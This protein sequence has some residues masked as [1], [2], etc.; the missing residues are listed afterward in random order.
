MSMVVRLCVCVVYAYR[1]CLNDRDVSAKK[2]HR[3][4][5]RATGDLRAY[6][7][8][9]S[10]LGKPAHAIISAAHLAPRRIWSVDN[11]NP[12]NTNIIEFEID[13][14][15]GNRIGRRI[16]RALKLGATTANRG[17]GRVL[18]QEPFDPNA[19]DGDNDGL[20]QD[21]TAF[22]RPAVLTS[23]QIPKVPVP[24][25]ALSSATPSE[26][27]EKLPPIDGPVRKPDPHNPEW[28][29]TATVDEL[30]DLYIPSTTEGYYQLL[31]RIEVPREA[32][33]TEADYQVALSLHRDVLEARQLLPRRKV[34]AMRSM[35]EAKFGPGSFDKDSNTDRKKFTSRVQTLF[36]NQQKFGQAM[37]YVPVPRGAGLSPTPAVMMQIQLAFLNFLKQNNI[38]GT[39]SQIIKDIEDTID[40]GE[41][42]QHPMFIEIRKNGEINPDPLSVMEFMLASLVAPTGNLQWQTTQM[43]QSKVRISPDVEQLIVQLLE[44]Y[45][46]WVSLNT[47][48]PNQILDRQQI[49]NRLQLAKDSGSLYGF[50]GTVFPTRIDMIADSLVPNSVPS[51]SKQDRQLLRA[52]MK[53]TLKENP[54]FLFAVRKFGLPPVMIPH[55]VFSWAGTDFDFDDEVILASPNNTSNRIRAARKELYDKLNSLWREFGSRSAE[56]QRLRNERFKALRRGTITPQELIALQAQYLDYD[57]GASGHFPVNPQLGG[58]FETSLGMVVLQH[59][60]T[61][62]SILKQSE[63]DKGILEIENSK[64]LVDTVGEPAVLVHEYAHYLDNLLQRNFAAAFW[65]SWKRSGRT[66]VKAFRDELASRKTNLGFGE[67][68]DGVNTQRKLINIMRK[69]RNEPEIGYVTPEEIPKGVLLYDYGNMSDQELQKVIQDL[70]SQLEQIHGSSILLNRRLNGIENPRDISRDSINSS[71]LYVVTPYGQTNTAERFAEVFAAAVTRTGQKHPILINNAAVKLIARILGLNVETQD[72]TR[73]QRRKRD[74]NRSPGQPRRYTDQM[75]DISERILTDLK[76]VAPEAERKADG[77]RPGLPSSTSSESFRFDPD[78]RSRLS[79]RTNL[80]IDTDE[81]LYAA[82]TPTLL[83][84]YASRARMLKIGDHHFYDKRVPF[85]S[86]LDQRMRQSLGETAGRRYINRNRPHHGDMVRAIS[87]IQFG[88]FVDDMPIYD[89]TT[90]GNKDMLRGLVTGKIA[91]LPLSKRF[92]IEEALRDA[93][94]IHLAVQAVE[95]N[96]RELFRIISVDRETFL[97]GLNTGD[98]IP[99]PITA[100]SPDKPNKNNAVVIRLEKGAKAINLGNGHFLTQGNF[101]VTKIEDNGTNVIATLSHKEVFDPRHDAMRPVD[102][103]SDVPGKMRKMGAALARY[104]PEEQEKMN[105]ELQKRKDRTEVLKNRGLASSTNPLTQSE[106]TDFLDFERSNINREEYKR[107][108][109]PLLQRAREI[110]SAH[111]EQSVKKRLALSIQVIKEKYGTRTPW[112]DDADAIRKW[113]TIDNDTARRAVMVLRDLL[114]Q[115]G[116]IPFKGNP[117]SVLDHQDRIRHL[118][119]NL[120][121]DGSFSESDLEQLL[122]K[123]LYAFDRNSDSDARGEYS[124]E[125]Q[126]NDFVP[127]PQILN[128]QT[129]EHKELRQVLEIALGALKAVK[130]AYLLDGSTFMVGDDEIFIKPETTNNRSKGAFVRLI[131]DEGGERLWNY[132]ANSPISFEVKGEITFNDS[133]TGETEGSSAFTVRSASYRP[134]PDNYFER[135][136]FLNADGQIRVEHKNMFINKSNSKHKGLGTVL[137]QHAAL[138]WRQHDGTEMYIPSPV[139][140]GAIVW[141]RMNYQYNIASGRADESEFKEYRQS[142]IN[143]IRNMLR[144]DMF[145]DPELDFSSTGDVELASK[146]YGLNSD[147]R[148]RLIGWLALARYQESENIT[149]TSLMTILANIIDPSELNRDQKANWREFFAAS[150]NAPLSQVVGREDNDWLPALSIPDSPEEFEADNV[151]QKIRSAERAE[152]I[153]AISDDKTNEYDFFIQP[154]VD[155]SEGLTAQQAGRIEA[156]MRASDNVSHEIYKPARRADYARESA[157]F[158]SPPQLMTRV[159]LEERIAKGDKILY[160]ISGNT[161]EEYK[162]VPVAEQGTKDV[163]KYV[164]SEPFR[165]LDKMVDR[166]Q[167]DLDPIH[168]KNGLLVILDPKARLTTT[169][170]MGKVGKSLFDGIDNPLKELRE[171]NLEG[172]MARL[173]KNFG[174]EVEVET[175]NGPIKL[176]FPKPN[177]NSGSGDVKLIAF[178]LAKAFFAIENQRRLQGDSQRLVQ[179][180]DDF[181]EELVNINS[182]F[183]TSLIP[184][185]LGI[186]GLKDGTKFEIYNNRVIKILDEKVSLAE[187]ARMID[188]PAFREIPSQIYSA[189]KELNEILES[190][191]GRLSVEQRSTWY[192]DEGARLLPDDV[193]QASPRGLNSFTYTSQVRKDFNVDLQRNR[194]LGS[195]TTNESKQRTKQRLENRKGGY[196]WVDVRDSATNPI[197]AALNFYGGGFENT[198]NGIKTEWQLLRQAQDAWDA[199]NMTKGPDAPVDLDG[200]AKIQRRI[201]ELADTIVFL[202]NSSNN[203]LEEA[204]DHNAVRRA[205]GTII[206]EQKDVKD[207]PPRVIQK[208]EDLE[209]EFQKDAREPILGKLLDLR[210]LFKRQTLLKNLLNDFDLQYEVRKKLDGEDEI[211]LADFNDK[212]E[213]IREYDMS[214]WLFSLLF[215][216]ERGPKPGIDNEKYARGGPQSTFMNPRMRLDKVFRDI[217]PSER[218]KWRAKLDKRLDSDPNADYEYYQIESTPTTFGIAPEGVPAPTWRKIRAAMSRSRR[219][220]FNGERA[221]AEEAAMSM[222]ETHRPDLANLKFVRG[223]RSSTTPPVTAMRPNFTQRTI[224]GSQ[225]DSPL[226]N[227]ENQFGARLVDRLRGLGYDIEIADLMPTGKYGSMFKLVNRIENLSERNYDFSDP[228]LEALIQQA[229]A[230][231]RENMAV[232]KIEGHG[233]KKVLGPPD[234]EVVDILGDELD[235]AMLRVMGSPTYEKIVDIAAAFYTEKA[236]LNRAFSTP[237]DSFESTTDT[238]SQIALEYGVNPRSALYQVMRKPGVIEGNKEKKRDIGI[239]PITFTLGDDKT[240]VATIGVIDPQRLKEIETVFPSRY[241]ESVSLA[242]LLARL[243]ESDAR[244]NDVIFGVMNETV[245]TD[246]QSKQLARLRAEYAAAKELVGSMTFA[247]SPAGRHVKQLFEQSVEKYRILTDLAERLGQRYIQLLQSRG[248]TDSEIKEMFTLLRQQNPGGSFVN[249]EFNNP[250]LGNVSVIRSALEGFLLKNL[251]SLNLPQITDF[252]IDELGLHEIGHSFLGQGFTRHGEFVANFW[253]FAL[254]GPAFWPLFA[255]VQSGQERFD[256]FTIQEKFG[257]KLTS[258]QKLTLA[259]S[260]E[261]AVGADRGYLGLTIRDRQQIENS[262]FE[263]IDNDPNLNDAEKTQIKKEIKEHFFVKFS[264]AVDAGEIDD[265]TRRLAEEAGVD[266]EALH[267]AINAGTSEAAIRTNEL[268][269]PH[270]PLPPRVFGWM[271]ENGTPD[272]QPSGLSPEVQAVNR[273]QEF[274]FLVN[275][276]LELLGRGPAFTGD[277][278]PEQMALAEKEAKEKKNRAKK[279]FAKMV[280]AVNELAQKYPELGKEFAVE[281]RQLK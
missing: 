188:D 152:I 117:S 226:T 38:S 215:D 234:T 158:N 116:Q 161:N 2:S 92:P 250:T 56:V 184:T 230:L 241:G 166:K 246:Y 168:N 105:I 94:A 281:L 122:V 76:V 165:Y 147:F 35:Y 115:N 21:G 252:T 79:S 64:T 247:P 229:T 232:I 131:G 88:L 279:K 264:N 192:L 155:A 3:N 8:I 191:N 272:N 181:L 111:I 164:T 60:V 81:R 199:E 194:G 54:E 208:L 216:P 28:R 121:F 49:L 26:T 280:E 190:I 82:T 32:Y 112:K 196:S 119:A 206:R 187:A 130:R 114:E 156:I 104:S 132:S 214:L 16:G 236:R 258:K 137:Q 95:P 18:Y 100:F 127:M 231:A 36:G 80:G 245:G 24:R 97:E 63:S 83:T 148:Q 5:R 17:L 34:D 20:V 25:I 228:F 200:R 261:V 134:R 27:E 251:R 225:P 266:P 182:I 4:S 59:G 146:D 151:P 249:G 153:G 179:F 50:F 110:V 73:M 176:V 186:D 103:F 41:Y 106:M 39:I 278:T 254:Y 129:E 13:V 84:D 276:L 217:S 210:F 51:E 235:V 207:I 169:E 174:T 31:E 222:L 52:L 58:Y 197:L 43:P 89:T 61:L 68:L 44:T 171:Q 40:A 218:A 133:G 140:D 209:A 239:R 141:P 262:V 30:V 93:V 109:A 160:A 195:S 202:I 172:L 126:R 128:P 167:P 238:A 145:K 219:T 271:R 10:S 269:D 78:E 87:S 159:E 237:E 102:R 180:R 9:C 185:L 113:R 74:P 14:K 101:E 183:R 42:L 77:H 178:R 240:V 7:N 86:H 154:L 162:I 257:H 91:K 268:L 108:T 270:I 227:T 275:V 107:K 256:R 177:I 37:A 242:S 6:L 150:N 99:M 212:D 205:L 85:A 57:K 62:I 143:R 47:N 139:S 135:T 123:G 265:K 29:A 248:I 23:Q 136:I 220:R 12:D 19:F 72:V 221:H 96:K 66:D 65:E 33:K 223:I 260:V 75:E 259:G 201:D 233:V 173:I 125:E 203:A 53:R 273:R 22:E 198:I 189:N 1:P 67:F 204:L 193:I 120:R 149:D 98:S 170:Q 48:M 244:T 157:G 71:E 15:A 277:E 90:E 213:D 274:Q 45:L 255:R 69:R 253:P 118:K 144:A 138:W 124:N 267:L 175:D 263:R 163:M 142:L 55:R 243:D 11:T 211:E 46:N 70:E 224:R